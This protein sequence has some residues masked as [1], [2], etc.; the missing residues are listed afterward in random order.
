MITTKNPGEA[1]VMQIKHASASKELKERLTAVVAD[2]GA[3]TPLNYTEVLGLLLSPFIGTTKRGVLQDCL[4]DLKDI[5]MQ[6]ISRREERIYRFT[7]TARPEEDEPDTRLETLGTLYVFLQLLD[8]LNAD[9]DHLYTVADLWQAGRWDEL[10][11]SE[12][13]E[14]NDMYVGGDLLLR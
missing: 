8:G 4:S 7:G 13:K 5:T 9:N 6:I 14:L 2:E 12:R 10:T 11:T 1:L 3:K